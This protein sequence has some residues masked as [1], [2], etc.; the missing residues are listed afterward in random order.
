[1]TPV[2]CLGEFLWSIF[3]NL[4]NL[5]WLRSIWKT[6]WR[7]FLEHDS[8]SVLTCD[9]ALFWKGEKND[10]MYFREGGRVWWQA[11]SLFGISSY[12]LWKCWKSLVEKSRTKYINEGSAHHIHGW[13]AHERWLLFSGRWY[14]SRQVYCSRETLSGTSWRTSKNCHQWK[15]PRHCYC[16]HGL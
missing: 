13:T 6:N 10:E 14:H 9:Q 3:H 8:H 5:L 7:I 15:Y 11:N 4:Y 2:Q 1:M 16:Y 12:G